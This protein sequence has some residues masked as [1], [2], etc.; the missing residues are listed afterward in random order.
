[1]D[2]NTLSAGAGKAEI[3]FPQEMFPTDGFCGVHDTPCLR[4]LVLDC[5][6]RVAIA[7]AELVN[8]PDDAISQCQEMI[9][10]KTG[11]RK[12]NVWIHAT[13]AIT[14]PHAPL[15][16]SIPI[17][18]PGGRPPRKE[19]DRKNGEKRPGPPMDP[20][21]PRKRRLFISAILEATKE[22]AQQAADSFG[23][24][25]LGVGT[26][27]CDVNVNRDVETPFGWW[28]GINPDGPSN[29]T[30]TVIKV[31][32]PGGE[33]IGYL[34]S[35][36]V[37]PCAVDNSQ[38]EQKTRLVS[39]DVPGEA[40]RILEQKF[41]APCLFVMS[42]AGDQVPKE[43][44]LTEY[45]T[46]EGIVAKRDEGVQKGLEMVS[47]LGGEMAEAVAAVI[48][49]TKCTVS[50][51]S[52]SRG[53]ASVKVEAK[54]RVPMKPVKNPVFQPDGRVID[55]DADLI[56]IGDL[57]L[58]A[59][60]PETNVPTEAQLQEQSPFSHTLLMSMVNGGMKYM[61]DQDSYDRGTWEALSSMLMPGCAEK[62]VAAVTDALNEM[63][64]KQSL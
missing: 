18:L 10:D 52:I 20:D 14:T 39:A 41:G 58:V 54:E 36:G 5:G 26:G 46:E 25:I 7:A 3:I 1:M 29:K 63:K 64:E 51:P 17:N 12:E 9:S 45:V 60:K 24:A 6:V 38:M 62:W 56:T 13:H 43:Q 4:I 2:Y 57:A 53:A 59:V 16:P 47:R 42:A 30:A 35:Y 32:N 21:G 40:C 23:P 44:A 11:T 33:P 55:L 50:A 37:K 8:V 15:D 48:A 22:A 28:V 49:D 31:E 61:P 34:I 27:F 19:N